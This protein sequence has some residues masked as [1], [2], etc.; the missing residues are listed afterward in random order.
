MSTL[1]KQLDAWA[2]EAG[3]KPPLILYGSSLLKLREMASGLAAAMWCENGDGWCNECPVCQQVSG[4]WHPDVYWLETE[5]R[6]L[7]IKAV[8][9]MINRSSTKGWSGKKAIIISEA[10][11]LT[12]PAINA[13]LKTLEEARG[14]VGF[15]LTS[16]WP[17][18]LSATLRSRCQMINLG[19]SGGGRAEVINSEKSL[20][21]ADVFRMLG[22][23]KEISSEE[24]EEIWKIISALMK[25]EG[26]GR[27]LRRATGRLRDFYK[28]K[29][30]GGN[31]KIA[32]DVLLGELT[33]IDMP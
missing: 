13:L 31:V 25:S 1:P 21:K 6:T 23:N 12:M 9:E 30:G 16:R 24:L 14:G 22:E 7:Q 4:A 3:G 29:A 2:R 20:K 11:K 8:R 10:E 19:L 28:I 26:P 32:K 18:R 15:I 33:S 17:G 27:E 5:K